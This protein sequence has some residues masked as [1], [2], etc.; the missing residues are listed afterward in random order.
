MLEGAAKLGSEVIVP[1]TALAQAWRGGQR[2]VR[3][4]RWVT[5]SEM[6][7]LDAHRARQIG[8]RIGSRGTSDVV[9]AHAFCCAIEFEAALVT[10]DPDDMEALAEPEESPLVVAI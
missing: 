3:L 1:T 7:T 2:S 5:Q 4:A 8:E 10:S 9:D 6:D